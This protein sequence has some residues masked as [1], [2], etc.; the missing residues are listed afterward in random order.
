MPGIITTLPDAVPVINGSGEE[1]QGHSQR[2]TANRVGKWEHCKCA[3]T[4]SLSVD[5]CP[6]GLSIAM[7]KHQ[8]KASW[9]RKDS[10]HPTGYSSWLTGGRAGPRSW[11][12]R[13]MMST[14]LLFMACSACILNI[15]LYYLLG[16]ATAHSEL[17]PPSIITSQAMLHT[18]PTSHSDVG[19][20][21][22][23]LPPSQVC[24]LDNQE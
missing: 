14:D 16:N 22:F 4:F 24:P 12:H 6:P 19:S 3:V 21:S 17:G 13:E 1:V 11:S 8:P 15:I 2:L 7:I 20:P 10:F 23:S 9:G 18:M 5:F